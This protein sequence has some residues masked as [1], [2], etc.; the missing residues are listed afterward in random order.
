MNHGKINKQYYGE[1]SKKIDDIY[2]A[3]P[4]LYKMY[5][6]FR[7]LKKRD[8]Y[9][10][11]LK[12]HAITLIREMQVPITLTQI[13]NIINLTNH[14]TVINL[15]KNYKKVQNYDEFVKGFDYYVENYLY[16]LTEKNEHK[17]NTVKYYNLVHISDKNPEKQK[18]NL[19]V[20]KKRVVSPATFS[21]ARQNAQHKS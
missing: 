1:L 21:K 11:A 13:A 9:Y 15:E 16:P 19:I 3:Y 10:V 18:E 8:A 20:G 14:A 17:R 6:Y 12:R 5:Q 4:D 2:S 7:R